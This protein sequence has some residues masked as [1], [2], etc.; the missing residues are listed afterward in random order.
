MDSCHRTTPG[1][2]IGETLT[3]KYTFSSFQNR[4]DLEFQ[5]SHFPVPLSLSMYYVEPS[6]KMYVL[7]ATSIRVEG[8]C[9]V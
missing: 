5:P 3:L 6:N 1:C 9:S 7:L 8:G 4:S 2:K